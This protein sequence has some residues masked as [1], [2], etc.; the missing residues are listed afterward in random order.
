[1]GGSISVLSY[2]LSSP[3]M[4]AGLSLRSIQ[5]RFHCRAGS[6]SFEAIG[7]VVEGGDREASRDER[8]RCG[9][10]DPIVVVSAE[11]ILCVGACFFNFCFCLFPTLSRSF[12]YTRHWTHNVS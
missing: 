7:R 6:R 8:K 11:D 10:G 2:L 3:L 12:R 5:W 1:M 4:S 9:I